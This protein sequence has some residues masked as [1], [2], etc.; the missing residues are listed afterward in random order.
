MPEPDE[1]AGRGSEWMEPHAEEELRA[2][3][4]FLDLSRADVSGREY[5]ELN[6]AEEAE[7]QALV[8]GR[9]D[10]WDRV[11]LMSFIAENGLA[12]QRLAELL[13]RR[14]QDGSRS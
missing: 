1:Q 5:R 7:L 4:S 8:E 9:L 2:L 12:L 11:R 13:K 10:A 3:L 6:A 14:E